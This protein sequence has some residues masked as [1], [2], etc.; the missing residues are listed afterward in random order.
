MAAV[1]KIP[2][3]L[4]DGSANPDY[5]RAYYARNR[6]RILARNRAWR[7]AAGHHGVGSMAYRAIA[8]S[9]LRERD[10]DCCA[11]CGEP[12]PEAEASIDHIEQRAIGG[13]D[14]AENVRLTHMRC[15]AAR[16]RKQRKRR[17]NGYELHS[18]GD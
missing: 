11:L 4:P 1:E 13:A 16:P 15:N 6:E 17:P 5:F 12:I 3:R 7:R 9:L 8:V 10:G 18:V 2:T 14:S